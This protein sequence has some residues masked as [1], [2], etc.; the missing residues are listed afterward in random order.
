MATIRQLLNQKG[1]KVCSIGPDATVFDAVAKMAENDIGSL[2]VMDSEALIGIITERRYARNVVL[3][4]KTSPSTPVWEIMERDV[5]TVGPEQSVEECMALM[6]ERHV[7][8]LPVV[9]GEKVIGIVSMGDLVKSTIDDQ[10]LAID[11]LHHY[12]REEA[13]RKWR[14]LYNFERP[15]MT[16]KTL[17]SEDLDQFTGSENMRGAASSCGRSASTP[18]SASEPLEASAEGASVLQ[19]VRPN[20]WPLPRS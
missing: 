16:E 14:A 2:T 4:G 18:G 12:A 15:G 7:R 13:Y 3:K 8:H 9:E 10:K 17:K 1:G 20:W 19:S 11:Q 6:T 5:V